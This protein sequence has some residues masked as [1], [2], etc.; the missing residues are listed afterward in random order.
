[1]PFEFER[2]SIPE[3]ILV[4]PKKFGDDRGFFMETFKYSDFEKLG[5]KGPFRQDNHS[6]SIESNVLRGLHYQLDPKPQGKLVRVVTGS[7]FDVAIDI[8]KTSP[9]FGKWV[10]A[11]LTDK[12]NHMLWVPPGFAHGILTLEENTHLLYK[13]TSEYDPNLDR[14]IKWDDPDIS[15]DWPL[16]KLPVL[17]EKDSAAL[18]LKDAQINYI[19]ESHKEVESL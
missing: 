13:C 18:F 10:A 15:I 9:T 6:K 1:M 2:L 12:N 3:V 8:R 11:E 5:I 17:S 14:C 7:V 4:K 19:Y 16:D